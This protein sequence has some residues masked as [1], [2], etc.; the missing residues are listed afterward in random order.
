MLTR[1]HYKAIAAIVKDCTKTTDDAVTYVSS[2]Q[3]CHELAD[4][5]AADNPRFDRER[6]LTACGIESGH[7]ICPFT[8]ADAAAHHA[9]TGE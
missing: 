5:F 7:N 3:L 6:F 4:Y 9:L 8:D 2:S 1:K